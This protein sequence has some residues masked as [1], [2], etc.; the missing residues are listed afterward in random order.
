MNWKTEFEL[1][2][3]IPDEVERA[4]A[5]CSLAFDAEHLTKS[6]N[7]EEAIELSLLLETLDPHDDLLHPAIEAAFENLVALGVRSYPNLDEM[8][9]QLLLKFSAL[10]ERSRL[11]AAATA[12]AR[13]YSSQQPRAWLMAKEL[14]DQATAIGALTSKERRLYAEICRNSAT[15]ISNAG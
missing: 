10:D 6:G 11:L 7:T 14:F 1:A 9:T 2:L 5:L 15:Q 4:D 13:E 8:K 12:M 3:A